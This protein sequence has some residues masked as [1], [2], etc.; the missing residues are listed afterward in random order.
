MLRPGRRLEIAVSVKQYGKQ[1]VVFDAQG[2][3]GAEKIVQAENCVAEL[4]DLAGYQNPDDLRVLYSEIG[5]I[6]PDYSLKSRA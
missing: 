3:S 4:A 5:P 2:A 1:C 6:V